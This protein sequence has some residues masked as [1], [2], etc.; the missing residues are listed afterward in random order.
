MSAMVTRGQLV[1]AEEA[2]DEERGWRKVVAPKQL[3]RVIVEILVGQ[4][5]RKSLRTY[6]SVMSDSQSKFQ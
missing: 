5:R 1:T 3:A 4:V 2:K 6:L